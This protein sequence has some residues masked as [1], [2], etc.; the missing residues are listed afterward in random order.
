MGKNLRHSK[1]DTSTAAKGTEKV[2]GNGESTNAGTTEGGSSGDNTLKLLVHALLTVTR[3]DKTLVLELLS[4]ITGSGAGDLNPGLGEESTGNQHEGNVD[5][6]VDRIQKSLLEVQRRRHVVRNTGGGVKLG[7]TL[8][9]LPDSE[10]LDKEVVGEAR[11]QHLGDEEDVGAQSGLQHDG[12]V[13]G[14]EETDG[15][16]TAHTTLAGGLDGDLNAEALQVDNGGEDQESGQQVHDVGKVLAV[17]SLVQST[18]LVGPGQEKVEQ[19]DDGT[20]ELGATTSVD[21]GGGEGLP[22]NGLANVGSDEE[23][24]TGAQTV[25]LLEEF[26][27]Q[28]DD[29][30]GNNQLDNQKDTDT[31]TKV[32]G[33]AVE[34]SQDVD[35]GLAEGKD[36]SEELLGGLVELAVGLQ[37]KVDIDEVGTGKELRGETIVS[38]M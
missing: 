16:R 1:Q 3:H 13:G 37:V 31:S 36:D 28:N 5:G 30:T 26:I 35:T 9:R 18:L 17:E 2:G 6:S 8:T 11:V 19:G 15:V 10:E 33:L 22:D 34:T 20:L 25:A 14:V 12:H 21:G 23:R 29:E 32:A 4:N 24:D 7:R 27:Q 38:L